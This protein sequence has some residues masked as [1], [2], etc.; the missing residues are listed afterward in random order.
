MNSKLTTIKFDICEIIH[1]SSRQTHEDL[2]NFNQKIG[3]IESR[4][5]ENYGEIQLIYDKV[6]IFY[7]FTEFLKVRTCQ[8]KPE[9]A[10]KPAEEGRG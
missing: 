2:I 3:E 5:E 1:G 6:R 9:I 7:F 4:L 10:S 8:H